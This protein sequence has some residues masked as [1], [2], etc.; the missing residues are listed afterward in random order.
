MVTTLTLTLTLTLGLTLALAL[1]LTLTLTLTLIYGRYANESKIWAKK[2][3]F[4][5]RGVCDVMSV[6]FGNDGA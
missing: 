5:K 6:A 1:T 3:V 4:G 2:G